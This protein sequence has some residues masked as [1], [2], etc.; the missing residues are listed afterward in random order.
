MLGCR[1]HGDLTIIKLAHGLDV[2]HP[3]HRAMEFMAE[4]VATSSGGAMRIDI[5]PSEQLGSERECVE[6]L[7][8]GSIGMTKVSASVA[9]SFIPS[10]Q[11]FSLPYLFTSREHQFTVLE[12]PIGRELLLEGESSRIRGLCYFDAGSRSFYTRERPVLSPDD[13]AGLKIR[14]QESATAM[15]MVRS[16]GG[17]ATPIAWGELYTALQQGVV[18]GAE[19]NPP[20]FYLSR[21]YEVCKYYSLDEHTSVPDVLLIGTPVWK[22]LSPDEQ[23]ILQEAA[24]EAARYQKEIWRQASE[25]ALDAVAAA[26]VEILHPDK[27]PF[28]ARVEPLLAEYRSRPEIFRWIERIRE[29]ASEIKEQLGDSP[30]SLRSEGAP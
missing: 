1:G 9:E 22:A 21:H 14:T 6:L 12:G 13:L 8:I 10:F 17:S 23:Q 24:W 29:A 2:T 18:D 4:R 25:E 11:V 3:V 28:A 27:T 30:T 19:N 16:L 5:Y 26:G 15:R 7:Q 20:S